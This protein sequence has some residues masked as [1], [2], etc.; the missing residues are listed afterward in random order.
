[1]NGEEPNQPRRYPLR[2]H[3][4]YSDPESYADLGIGTTTEIS[5]RELRFSTNEQLPVG[6]FVRVAVD[7]PV[8]LDVGCQLRLIIV[9]RVTQSTNEL[10]VVAIKQ[11]EFRTRAGSRSV[12]EILNGSVRAFRA[13]VIGQSAAS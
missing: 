2:L 3:V 13:R 10:S 12:Q 7:W 1:M 11:Y 8:E 9:G 4:K 6:R 5:S